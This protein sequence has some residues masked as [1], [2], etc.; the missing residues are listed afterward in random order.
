MTTTRATNAQP[1]AVR[2]FS[3]GVFSKL[4]GAVTAGMIHLGDRLGLYAFLAENS[5]ITSQELAVGCGLHERWVRE[6][7]YNQAAAKLITAHTSADGEVRFGLTDEA[8]AVLVSPD[9]P[10]Y[11]M[12]MFHRLPQTMRALEDMPA[13]FRTGLGFDYDSHG[14]EGAVGIERSFEPWN[15]TFLLPVVVPAIQGLEQRLSEGA[16]VVDIGCGAGGAAM[17]LAQTFPKS[18]FKGY[19]ISHYA[20]ERAKVRQAE[21]NLSNIKFVD[22]RTEPILQDRSVDFVMTFD[23]IHDMTH[24]QE[25]MQTIR[26]A[27]KDDGVWLLVDIK[28][29]DGLEQNM[30]KNPMASLMYGISILSCMSSAMSS[31][32]GA[33]LGTLGFSATRAKSMAEAAGF[34]RFTQLDIEHSVNAFYEIR[35]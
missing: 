33:G 15:Q 9:H 27:L 10:A 5:N 18:Q 4:E 25:M 1:D 8:V 24:P 20:L 19:D 32:D 22:P 28:A 2:M 16:S 21:K 6:W 26:G 7:A 12:G 17:L 29:L 14:P 31:A 23:C 13:S 11:G 3:F 35:P 34:S 30:A